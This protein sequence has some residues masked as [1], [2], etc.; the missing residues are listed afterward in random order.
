MLPNFI[1]EDVHGNLLEWPIAAIRRKSINDALPG[2]GEDVVERVVSQ[3]TRS[4]LHEG[5]RNFAEEDICGD[6]DRK[7]TNG[8]IIQHRMRSSAHTMEE[9]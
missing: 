1:E 7:P 3:R 8:L 9:R 5:M 4:W 6:V 2:S